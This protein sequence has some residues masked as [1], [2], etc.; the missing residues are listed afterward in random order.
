MLT[1]SYRSLDEI[2]LDVLRLLLDEGQSVSPRGISTIELPAVSFTLNN[3]RSRCLTIPARRW[4]FPLALGELCWHLSGDTAVAGLSYYAPVW[5]HFA[6]SS[7]H[8]R[9]SCY[10]ATMFAS[11]GKQSAWE[12]VQ[13]LLSLDRDTRRAVIYLANGASNLDSDCIDAA[14][15]TSIQ[16]LIRGDKLDVVLTMRSNDAIWGLPYDVFLF[17][18]LQELMA[19]QLNLGIGKY[20]HF[21]GSLHLYER[22]RVL[23]ERILGSSS[24]LTEFEMPP[25]D[26]VGDLHGFL[27]VERQLRDGESAESAALLSGYWKQLAGV[28]QAFRGNKYGT[29]LAAS[30]FPVDAEFYRPLLHNPARG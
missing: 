18:F 5:D 13:R 9:G 20:Y 21:A 12:A 15:A 11:D 28:L 1:R 29:R 25:I 8:I 7:G 3:P 30:Q 23:A 6:D 4:S 22:H 27:A 10:G 24:P 19:K 17:T 14:C 26:T 2:Q 16:F